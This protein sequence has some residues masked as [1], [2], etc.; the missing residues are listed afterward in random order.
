[1]PK[2]SVP[3]RSAPTAAGVKETERKLFEGLARVMMFPMDPSE[4]GQKPGQMLPVSSFLRI[5]T[6]L[7]EPQPEF[8]GPIEQAMRHHPGLARAEAEKMAAAFGFSTAPT[9]DEKPPTAPQPL[10]AT[11]RRAKRKPTK[12]EK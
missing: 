6:D 10:A 5:E 7:P 9:D 4:P 12:E 3:P 2:K 11:P 1:M 8:I